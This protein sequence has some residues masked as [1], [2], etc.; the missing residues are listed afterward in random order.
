MEVSRNNSVEDGEWP[1]LNCAKDIE[2]TIQQSNR[3]RVGKLVVVSRFLASFLK[4]R[5]QTYELITREF[6]DISFDEKT[7]KD[8]DQFAELF[9]AFRSDFPQLG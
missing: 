3:H 1:S 6:L 9:F 5:P 2:A 4:N 7:L 8:I